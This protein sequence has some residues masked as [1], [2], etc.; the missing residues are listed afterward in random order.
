LKH[1]TYFS[2][3]FVYLAISLSAQ[4]VTGTI[5]GTILDPTG[6]AVPQAKVAIINLDRNQVVRTITTEASGVYS[7]PFLPVGSYAVRAEAAGFKTETHSGIALNV[8]DV[9][10]INLTMQVGAVTETVEVT[11]S[12][13]QVEL[14][15]PASAGTVDS[16]Q[17]HELSLATRNYEQLLVLMPGVISNATDELY[18][19]NSLPSGS[20]A[21][22]PYS[23]NGARNSSNNW[24]VDGADNVDRGSNLTLS[25]FPSVDAI[26]Q[27]KVQRASYT[28]DAGRAGGAQV[29]VVTKGGTSKFHGNLYEY[30]RNDVLY[31]NNWA[32]NA[33]KVNLVNRTDAT[34]PCTAANYKDCYA[35]V[36]PVRWNDF[37]FTIGGPVPLGKSDHNKT[38]FFYSQEWHKVINYATFNPI[39]PTQAMLAGNFS[40]PVCVE[41]SGTTC[42]LTGTSIPTSQWNSNSA[43]YVKDIFSKLPLSATNTATAT[44]SGFFPVRNVY[45]ARQEMGRID[46]TFSERFS[47]YGRFTIDDIPTTEAG[48]LFGQSS[49][50]GMATTQTNSPGR[51]AVLHTVNIIRPSIV[52]DAGF[53]FSQSAILTKPLGLTAKSNSP[54]IN[55]KEPFTNPEGV[56]PSIAFGGFLSGANGAGPYTDYNRN[57]AWFDNLTWMKGRHSVKFGVSL[58]KYQKTENANSG[59]GTFTFNNLGV[60]TG[61]SNYQQAWANFLLGNVSSFTQP[62]TD[63]S[64]DVRAWQNE[65]YVQDDF[66]VTSRLTLYGG[67]RWSFFGQP[68]D[69]NGIMTNFDPA[70]YDPAKAP[71]INPANGTVIPGTANWQLNGII[72]GG[73]NSP[74]GDKISNDSY[75]NFAPR[76]GLAWDPFGTGKT[77]IR[78]GYGIYYDATL[79]GTYEQNQFANPPFVASVN[80]TNANFSDVSSG[81][82]GIS[83]LSPQATSVLALHATQLPANVPYTQNWNLTIQ[84]QIARDTVLEVAYVGSKGTH[85]QGVVDLNEA[86]PGAAYAAGLHQ[87]NGNTVFTTADE[88]NINAVKPFRGFAGITAIETAFDSNYHSLQVNFRRNFHGGGLLGVVYTYGKVLTDNGSDR[89][90]APQNSYNWHEGEYSRA[91]WD[92]TQV[93][94]VNYVYTLPF[95]R[96]GRGILPTALGGWELS[97]ILS[98]YTGQPLTVTTGSVDP[99]GLGI[100]STG[101]AS[102]RPDQICN[103]NTNAPHQ[104]GANA[105]ANHWFNTSC[106]AAVPQGEIRP[107]NAGRFTVQGPG[108]FNLDASIFKNFNLSRE[109]RWKLQLRG[110]SF[111][112]LNWVNP[113][114]IGSGSTTSTLFGIVTSYRAPRRMQLGA[115]ITF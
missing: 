54:D 89:N 57:Y 53:N 49:V 37:G 16:E 23:V 51:G 34:A 82:A 5:G 94:T 92:R 11:S 31:A 93:L 19:G 44:T 88:P 28:A 33:N 83:P 72:V 52:N 85:L 95:F 7:A 79:F 76:I 13:A 108:F 30:F 101:P 38:F 10:K 96:H 105:E 40:Q 84:R 114:G 67:V 12:A 8:N 35:K 70:L 45:D 106:F 6:A 110:E 4:E 63:I 1:L 102:V 27:F 14:G 97:G 113:S 103:P 80:Y 2:A 32:N 99:A 20:A 71:T 90:N 21:T 25:T 62:S 56:V 64:P 42:T 29:N 48:G 74:F 115:R 36:P 100:L 3:L 46:H 98:T 60:P 77:S 39:L 55:P 24:T 104:Y 22:I 26:Q 78:A 81:T 58:N 59:Q 112:T 111:N 69:A 107:G 66:K 50:P 15:S 17:V 73:Q 43:A 18:I 75:R 109:G 87:P 65:A 41:F 68:H 9:L 47:L 86:Y 91:P 61:T